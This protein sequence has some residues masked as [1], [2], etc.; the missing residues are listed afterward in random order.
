M[1]KLLK[2]VRFYYY[3]FNAVI[4]R[5]N[6]IIRY[7]WN[8]IMYEK[9]LDLPHNTAKIYL[10]AK[11]VILCYNLTFGMQSTEPGQRG[12]GESANYMWPEGWPAQEPVGK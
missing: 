1:F 12:F 10:S 8:A 2:F 5:D 9:I 7:R 4:A 11:L 3:S 6:T